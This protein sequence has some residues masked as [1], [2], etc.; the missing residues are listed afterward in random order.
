MKEKILIT[1]GLGNL[2]SWL[3]AHFARNN[4]EVWVLSLQ[5]RKL[6]ENIDYNFLQCDISDF[7]DCQKK[8]MDHTFEY[9]IHTASVND[10]FIENYFH[11][12]ILVN[13]L[14]TRNLLE[15][16]KCKPI[17]HFI[18]IST[19]QVYGTYAGTITED[20]PV[21]P[22][23]DY[24]NTH[25]FAEFYIKQF[26]QI[27]GLPYT[28]IR[29]TNGYGCPKDYFSSKWYLTLN[30]LTKKAFEEKQIILTSNGN[31]LRDFIWMGDVC[32]VLQKL[33]EKAASNTTYNLSGEKTLTLKQVAHLVLEA[34]KEKYNEEIPIIINTKD[35]TVYNNSLFVS[36]SKLMRLLPYQPDCRLM[37]EAKSIFNFLEQKC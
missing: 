22:R 20:T 34:Y 2:G 18:Y 33:V 8:L 7:K 13:G 1:G 11:S 12:A 3:T 31:A 23:N 19:F 17:K 9:I 37:E 27:H 4:F 16:F 25:L 28:I 32:K 26:N 5:E 6:T 14:G 35:T 29:L 21:N 15:L 24:S 30:S 36:S 10:D